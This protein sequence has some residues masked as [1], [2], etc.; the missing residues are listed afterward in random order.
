MAEQKT[1]SGGGGGVSGLAFIVGGLVVAVLVIAFFAYDGNFGG[2]EGEVDVQV[3]TPATGG[4]ETG[5]GGG[6]TG[7]GGTQGGGQG[8]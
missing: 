6:N 3:E 8:Q 7:G 4:G 5:G 2:G 1:P